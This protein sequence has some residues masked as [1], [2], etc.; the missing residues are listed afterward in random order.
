MVFF[1][2]IYFIKI[3][4]CLLEWT[5]D[6]TTLLVQSCYS[7]A[8]CERTL[9]PWCKA[10]ADYHA[11]Q[12]WAQWNHSG[13]SS[14]RTGDKG[15]LENNTTH[16][17]YCEWRIYIGIDYCSVISPFPIAVTSFPGLK[18]VACSTKLAQRAWAC[19]HVMCTAGRVFRS[20]DNN[21]A[22]YMY[23]GV[24]S[25]NKSSVYDRL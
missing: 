9:W 13:H 15:G 6:L 12:V 21:V 25:W 7:I 5:M 14:R 17:P 24:R 19:H 1:V 11:G 23:N 20:A 18:F 2:L 16:Y 10:A 8:G 4:K 3:Y 22:E